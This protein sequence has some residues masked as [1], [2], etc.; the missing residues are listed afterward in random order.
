M[1]MGFSVWGLMTEKALKLPIAAHVG[2]ST[3]AVGRPMPLA[4]APSAL[5]AQL[6]SV[7]D[8][9]ASGEGIGAVSVVL[10]QRYLWL[11]SLR[12]EKIS[13]FCTRYFGWLIGFWT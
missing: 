1:V 5:S 6:A 7:L 10:H 12:A 4:I 11:W 9:G 8:R 2:R 3:Q 13:G